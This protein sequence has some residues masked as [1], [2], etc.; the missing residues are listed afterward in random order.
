MHRTSAIGC[1]VLT[2]L[3]ATPLLAAPG[4]VLQ[5]PLDGDLKDTSGHA[6]DAYS[7]AAPKFEAGHNGQALNTQRTVSVPDSAELRLAPGLTVECWVKYN[8]LPGSFQ[9]IVSKDRNYMLRINQ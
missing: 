2:W 1:L 3:L 8:V 7:V 6:N 5:L 9:T 4:P